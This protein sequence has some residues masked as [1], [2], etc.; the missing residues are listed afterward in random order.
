VRTR[1]WFWLSS[2]GFLA[3]ACADRRPA[4]AGQG[5]TPAAET[6]S[7]AGVAEPAGAVDLA[8]SQPSAPPLS[9]RRLAAELH[10]IS[11]LAV[12]RDG[13]VFAHGDED[14]TVYQLDPRTGEVTARF[15][16]APTGDDP[17]LG[18]KGG[19]GRLAG[20]FED[21]AIA[22]DRFFLVSSNGVLLEFA[23]GKDGGS[24]PYRAY[25]TGLEKVCEVEGLAHDPSTESLLLL[26]KTMR[27]KS[28]RRQT[29]VYAWS[30]SGRALEEKPRFVVPWSA[31]DQVTGGKGF[32]GSALA[33]VPGGRSLL[34]VAGPQ[35]LFAEVGVDGSPIRGGALDQ[36]TLSQPEGLAFLPDGTLLAASEGGKGDAVLA[37][38]RSSGSAT[39][40]S[41]P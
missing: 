19:G 39:G 11:G 25:P 30:L 8:A 29:A 26:C 3:A 6:T 40:A 7:S 37:S 23:E 10:E 38:Y 35:R 21:I 41:P 22:G 34:M 15:G 14:A 16:L 2:L 24:V 17:D 4:D 20:D 5:S 9:Q 31:L 13:R 18:K 1:A 36:R 28:E 27:E 12:T 33:L 32:N